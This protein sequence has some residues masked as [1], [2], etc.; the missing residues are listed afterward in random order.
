MSSISIP[1][2]EKHSMNLGFVGTSLMG[3]HSH[4][5]KVYNLTKEGHLI[6]NDD[7]MTGGACKTFL[8]HAGL[9]VFSPLTAVIHVVRS[10][11]FVFYGQIE[12]AKR[13]F[14]GGLAFPFVAV[15][16]AS[17]SLLARLITCING[18]NTFYRN[19]RRTY[20]YFEAWVNNI[21]LRENHAKSYAKR[22]TKN[23]LHIV[24]L[25]QEE[26]KKSVYITAPCMQ[27]IL[28]QG[29]GNRGG[30]L[31]VNRMQKLFPFLS[32]TA[33]TQEEKG[34]KP[35]VILETEKQDT[36]F[37]YQACDGLVEHAESDVG[38]CCCFRIQTVYDRFCF[39]QCGQGVCRNEIS[40]ASCEITTC[41]VG[42]IQLCCCNLLSSENEE[43]ERLEFN[44][45]GCFG[46]FGYAWVDNYVRI[47]TDT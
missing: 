24:P 28:E 47:R 14:L 25:T 22:V 46:P 29:F 38:C 26:A 27:P 10:V 43:G 9:M 37:K 35:I 4:P 2:Y 1:I 30:L 40:D 33:I 16:C 5:L 45:K 8:K 21:D 7:Q 3:T 36:G 20:G 34:N 44:A 18:K 31:D 39:F 42:N 11:V 41:G 13:S 15:F 23:L 19:F 6:F 12:K 17:G 32:I